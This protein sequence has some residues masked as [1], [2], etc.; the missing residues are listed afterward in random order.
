MLGRVPHGEGGLPCAVC[1]THD[2]QFFA[3]HAL[4]EK[5]S[6]RD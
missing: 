1:T 5:M 2:D 6:I 4:S 3:N